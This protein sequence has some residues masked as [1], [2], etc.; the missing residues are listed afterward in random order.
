MLTFINMLLA[1]GREGDKQHPLLRLLRLVQSC[2]FTWGT[3]NIRGPVHFSRCIFLIKDNAADYFPFPIVSWCY[4]G[5]LCLS[6]YS[7]VCLQLVIQ[8]SSSYYFEGTCTG[9]YWVLLRIRHQ[10]TCN[11]LFCTLQIIYIKAF[12]K[13]WFTRFLCNDSVS[14][15]SSMLLSMTVSRRLCSVHLQTDRV[16]L[17][18]CNVQASGRFKYIVCVPW[19]L[20]HWKPCV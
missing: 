6:E 20:T 7:A 9:G 1:A 13:R 2:C 17:G 11:I 10:G 19:T 3:G 5:L 15:C 14:C 12:L 4:V 18:T 8:W 16:A